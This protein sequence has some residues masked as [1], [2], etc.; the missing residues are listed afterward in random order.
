MVVILLHGSHTSPPLPLWMEVIKKKK[1]YPKIPS[2][3]LTDMLKSIK[4]QAKRFPM[5]SNTYISAIKQ[6]AVMIEFFE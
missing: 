3:N 6:M 5:C 4:L 2:S 1:T